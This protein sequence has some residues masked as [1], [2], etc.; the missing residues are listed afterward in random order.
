MIRI[1]KFL[2]LNP[3]ERNV[4]CPKVLKYQYNNH[5][6]LNLDNENNSIEVISLLNYL[7]RLNQ[8]QCNKIKLKKY[9]KKF[10]KNKNIINLFLNKSFDSALFNDKENNKIVRLF[11]QLE[12]FQQEI[13]VRLFIFQFIEIIDEKNKIDKELRIGKSPIEYH[14]FMNLINISD[15]FNDYKN[16]FFNLCIEIFDDLEKK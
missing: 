7:S 8:D 6:I 9:D 1:F 14:S 3:L 12:K 15:K 5:L 16:I 11:S 4:K 10:I 13:F 2:S